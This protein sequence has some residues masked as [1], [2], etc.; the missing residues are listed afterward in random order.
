MDG[1]YYLTQNYVPTLHFIE[2]ISIEEYEDTY[3]I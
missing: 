2:L 1:I 3:N